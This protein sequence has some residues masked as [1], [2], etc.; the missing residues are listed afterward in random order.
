MADT[1]LVEI[2]GL[3]TFKIGEV[4]A[5]GAMG[6]TLV[7]YDK[8]KD[9][10]ATFDFPAPTKTPIN[11]YSLQTAYANILNGNPE[12]VSLEL[13][14][15][16][17][18]DLDEFLGGTFTA[19][20]AGTKD[21]WVKPAIIPTII[22]SVF[23]GSRDSQ[24]KTVGINFPRVQI[25]GGLSMTPSKTDGFGVKIELEILTPFDGSGNPLGSMYLEGDTVT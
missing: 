22:K 2:F 9:G 13:F 8:I 17:L 21:K 10:T 3:D 12:K 1:T 7:A 19:G 18:S 5:A 24:G 16:K 25:T 20:A 4:G 23:I 14:G 11:I 6:T 15:L